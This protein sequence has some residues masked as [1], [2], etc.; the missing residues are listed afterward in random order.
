MRGNG[1]LKFDLSGIPGGATIDSATLYLYGVV[2]GNGTFD[3]Y[4]ILPANGTW[5]EAEAMWNY[6][7]DNSFRWVGDTDNDGGVDA[8]ASV[9]GEDYSSDM[10]GQMAF[11]GTDG[12]E[13]QVAL[14]LTEFAAMIADNYGMIIMDNGS[15]ATYKYPATSDHVTAA[16]RPKLVVYYH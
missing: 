3:I 13:N 14:D 1:L 12:T 10:L 5:T 11:V 7:A 4:R 2:A 6:Q 16:R 9:K 15:S 8:G